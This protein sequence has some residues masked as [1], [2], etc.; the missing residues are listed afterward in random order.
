MSVLPSTASLSIRYLFIGSPSIPKNALIECLHEKQ[1]LN[2]TAVMLACASRLLGDPPYSA[3]WHQLARQYGGALP[4]FSLEQAVYVD[5]PS[6]ADPG[7]WRAAASTITSTLKRTE[8]QKLFFLVRLVTG[9]VESADIANVVTVMESIEQNGVPFSII[10]YE[11]GDLENASL[12][13][14]EEACKKILAAMGAP[15]YKATRVLF[16]R[17]MSELRDGNTKLNGLPR[18]VLDCIET[19][20]PVV[21]ISP[22][23]V[24]PIINRSFDQQFVLIRKEQ[25]LVPTDPIPVVRQILFPHP[26]FESFEPAEVV[27]LT[28]HKAVRA[29]GADLT[30]HP[31]W[32]VSI[33]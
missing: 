18:D 21:Q 7:T 14:G 10:A 25:M 8:Q 33:A 31:N 16:S 29:Q 19:E 6:L 9:R 4:Q 20:T 30:C 2:D 5:L 12:L 13:E 28:L 32:L 27:Y 3:E 17:A 26:A 22:A 15:R 23:L 11:A 1:Q 24:N